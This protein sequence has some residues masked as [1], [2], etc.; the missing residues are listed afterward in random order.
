[1]VASDSEDLK[2]LLIMKATAWMVAIASTGRFLIVDAVSRMST[3]FCWPRSSLVL[4][5]AF[6]VR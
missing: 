1:M 5:Y 2:M 3:S 6:S 4:M